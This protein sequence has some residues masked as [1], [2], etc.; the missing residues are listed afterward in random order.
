MHNC[1]KQYM[2]EIKK[3][4]MVQVPKLLNVT[5]TKVTGSPNQRRQNVTAEIRLPAVRRRFTCQMLY[6]NSEF[7][8]FF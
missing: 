4:G 6:E 8:N 3:Y 2:K 7:L 1:N 5:T